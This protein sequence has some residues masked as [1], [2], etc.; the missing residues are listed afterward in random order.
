MGHPPTAEAQ[1]DRVGRR[2]PG[3]VLWITAPTLPP[4]WK[5]SFLDHPLRFSAGPRPECQ[6]STILDTCQP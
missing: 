2:H 4:E 1:I 6:V 5:R 3:L